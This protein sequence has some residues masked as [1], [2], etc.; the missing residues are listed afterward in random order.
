ECGYTDKKN[1]ES[2]ALF[3]CLS[4]GYTDKADV[5]AAKNIIAAGLAVQERGGQSHIVS[6]KTQHSDPVKR[7]TTPKAA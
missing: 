7:T 3:C 2:Q 4:C 1:R 6:N 5:N